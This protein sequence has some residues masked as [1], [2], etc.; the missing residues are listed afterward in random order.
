[1]VK[2][3]YE[4]PLDYAKNVQNNLKHSWRI[5]GEGRERKSGGDEQKAELQG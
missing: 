3:E 5:E 2:N 1:M 4:F